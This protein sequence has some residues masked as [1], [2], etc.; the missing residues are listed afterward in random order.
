VLELIVAPLG[1]PTSEN[2]SVCAGRSLSVA[3]AVNV[4]ARQLGDRR[5]RRHVRDRRRRV[6]L[7]HVSVIA[8]S[9]F[10]VPSLT[11]TVNG[12]VPVPA[13]PSASTRTRPVT[14]VDG[15]ARRR[16]DQRERQRLRGRSLSVAGRVNVYGASSGIVAL[17][18]TFAIAGAA[19][20]SVTVSVIARVRVRGA[21]AHPHA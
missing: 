13:L 10:A 2:V 8:A 14:R 19:F 7:G 9:A 15:C 4:Y 17:A 16:A 21:V 3:V 18:G 6:R 12:Y 5:A 1:A 11:R 20:T